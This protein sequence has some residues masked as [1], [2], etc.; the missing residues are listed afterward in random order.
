[1]P[2]FKLKSTQFRRERVESWRELE[3]LLSRVDKKGL[4][5]LKH[6]ELM[7]L[8]TLYRGAV[9]SLSVARAISLD[10]NLLEYLTNLT[11]RAYV[12]VYSSK[13]RPRDAVV[14][15]L[16]RSWPRAVRRY[17][18]YLAASVAILLLGALC[19]YALTAVDPERYYSFVPEEAAQGRTPATP[20][21]ELREVLYDTDDTPLATL[22]AFAAF[23]FTHN[24]KIGILCFA[25]GFAAGAP[26]V[27]LLFFNGL[28]FGAMTA[29]YASRG[30]GSEFLA[31]VL[32]HG[33]TEL[34]AVCLCGA[35]G[36]VFGAAVV[37]PGRHSRLAGIARRGRRVGQVVIGAVVMLF[38]AALLEGFFRQ[39]VL[40]EGV[41]WTVA[42]LTAMAWAFFYSL[43]G[44]EVADAG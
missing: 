26:T 20:T 17:W 40:H 16:T 32:P 24:A 44:R 2:H 5:G 8:P 7:R 22:N 3:K 6:A 1:M 15:F 19:G 29:L 42:A 11:S 28:I 18:P 23:L 9:S 36:L 10:R 38:L 37:F 27:L 41:R 14:D 25:L 4:R 33:V 35:A 39:L 30:L 43:C 21:E 34:L 31:W 13:K 12:V